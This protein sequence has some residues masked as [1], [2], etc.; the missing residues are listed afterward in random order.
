MILNLVISAIRMSDKTLVVES[1]VDGR[2]FGL[3]EPQTTQDVMR[4]K[5]RSA[6]CEVGYVLA[7]VQVNTG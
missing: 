2:V 6:H 7:F 3:L 1:E 4:K 5:T